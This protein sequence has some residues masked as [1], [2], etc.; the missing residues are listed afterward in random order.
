[1]LVYVLVLSGCGHGAQVFVVKA[2]AAGIPSFAPFFDEHEGLGHDAAVR[3]QPV[4]G[5][6]QQ[7]DTPGLYGGTGKPTICDVT[8]LKRF[9][10]DPANHQKAQAWAGVLDITP[11][12][13]PDYLD[14]LTPVL[15]RH[16]TLVENHDYKQGNAVSFGSLL[17]AGI[18]VLVDERGLPAVKCS[19]GNPLRPYQRNAARVSVAFGNGDRKWPGYDPAS[20]VTVRPAPHRLQRLALVDVDRP[21]VGIDRPVGTT[22][23]HDSVFDAREQRTVPNLTGV[24]FAEASRRL[25]A[26]GLAAG[27]AGKAPPPDDARVTASDP[28]AGTRLPFGAYVT[29][30][31]AAGRTS[32][33][34]VAPPGTTPIVPPDS[35]TPD[36]GASPPPSSDGSGSEPPSSVPSAPP[37]SASSAPSS[38]ARGHRPP[39][40][41]S[42][43]PAGPG[44]RSPASPPGKGAASSPRT[45]SPS[46]SSARSSP[47]ASEPPRSSTPGGS[48]RAPSRP[49]ST[50]LT[51]ATGS[52][53]GTTSRPPERTRSPAS[54]IPAP[55]ATSAITTGRPPVAGAPPAGGPTASVRT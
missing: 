24:A 53:P 8:R 48:S 25:T 45:P 22:G 2:V 34:A 35:G 38:S 27:Y 41:R 32:G 17:Q 3:S 49:A 10:T 31:V 30:N 13:I 18:A 42:S 1:M 36:T 51:P 23:R 37:S 44:A 28:P 26:R 20:L 50:T 12:G 15:L 19:C 4:R 6:L 55:P 52:G 46:G 16:D 43:S 14:R 11:A 33:G 21:G 47:P 54:P 5:S 29:L 7:G 40:G 9:L 39:S